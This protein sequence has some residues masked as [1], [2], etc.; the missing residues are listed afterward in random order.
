MFNTDYLDQLYKD[1]KTNLSREKLENGSYLINASTAEL[2]AFFRQ[3]AIHPD[4]FQQPS[5]LKKQ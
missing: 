4:A 5:T 2:Q 3:F 1:G